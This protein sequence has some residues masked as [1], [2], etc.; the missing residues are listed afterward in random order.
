MVDIYEKM[1]HEAPDVKTIHAGLECGIFS[2]KIDNLDCISYGP[3]IDNIHTT[4]ERLNIDSARRCYEYTKEV[5]K[6]LK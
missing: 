6:A 4:E 3:Q 2:G 5:L 1:F